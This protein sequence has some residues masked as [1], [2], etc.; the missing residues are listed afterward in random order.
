M[1]FHDRSDAGRRLALRLQPLHGQD[2][3]VLGVPRGGIPVAFEVATALDAPLD[4]ILV[5]KLGVPHQP[6]LGFGAI[7]EDGVHI[8]N[9]IVVQQAQL[10]DDAM[11]EV[12][13]QEREELSRRAVRLRSAHPRIPLTGRTAL[14]VDDGVTTGATARTACRIAR[15]HGAARVVLA[16]PVAARD[17]LTPL[18]R[19]ADE[20]ICLETP[21]WFLAVG[22]WYRAFGQPT[23]DQIIELLDRAANGAPEPQQRIAHSTP[24][25]RDDEV[26]VIAGNIELT[27]HLTIPVDPIG[28]VV[29]A[30]PSGS[31]HHSPR[32]RHLAGVL[33]Q[34][35]LGT[36]VFDLLTPDEEIH[37]TRVFDIDLLAA[38]LVDV[39]GWLTRQQHT[40]GLPI[41]YFAA[42]TG[43]AAALRAATSPRVDIAAVVSRS[44]RPELTRD[45]LARVHAPTLLV[46]GGIDPLMLRLNQRAQAAMSCATAVMVVPGA[47][48]SFTEPGALQTVADLARDWFLTHLAHRRL[49]ERVTLSSNEYS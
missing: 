39:T 3:V 45:A 23:D 43:T 16:V 34:A 33:Q 18:K 19:E 46:V 10:T 42:D 7:G 44:G 36:L 6:E 24:P 30:N 27:G 37:R 35:G 21:T 41:G 12:E 40:E 9:D 48:R 26:H 1:L 15:A 13:H 28:L 8:V 17:A 49:H 4:V 2:I 47:T 38:R 14:I 20:V 29:F 25:L 31:G 5:R 32:N 22:Q 11:A